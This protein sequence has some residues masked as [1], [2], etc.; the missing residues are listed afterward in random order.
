MLTR[1]FL[2]SVLF[3][4]RKTRIISTYRDC[5]GGETEHSPPAGMDCETGAFGKKSALTGSVKVYNAISAS[6]KVRSEYTSVGVGKMYC[7]PFFSFSPFLDTK[8]LYI[9]QWSE[10]GKNISFF[11]FVCALHYDR[12]I[13]QTFISR[14]RNLLQSFPAMSGF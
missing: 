8:S 6:R 3:N 14:G 10:R 1:H 13:P 12:A 2:T 5:S 7:F 11:P 9:K 4:F